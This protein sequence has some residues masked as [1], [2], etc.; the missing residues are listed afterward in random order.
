LQAAIELALQSQVPVAMHLAESLEEL[1]LLQSGTGPLVDLL[2]R[3]QAWDPSALASMVRPLRYLQILSAA[4]RALAIHGNYL[5]KEERAF[6]AEHRSRMSLVYC[7]RTH[8][9]FGHCRYPLADLLRGGV[10]VALGTDSRASNPDLSVFEEMRFIARR[11]PEIA[12]VEIL[13]MG[14]AAGAE[15]LGQ[16]H[17]LGY[18]RRGYLARAA[19]ANLSAAPTHDAYE[20]LWESSSI[21]ALNL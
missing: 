16:D 21:C 7:P 12:P 15:A 19:V 8:F 17:E 13:R 5:D 18:L 20:A 14:T 6:L 2:Q 11:F 3:L 9:Y 4:P 10:R 1:E